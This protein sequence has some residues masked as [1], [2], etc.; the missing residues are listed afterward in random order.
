M[1]KS[2]LL[3]WLQEAYRQWEVFL[4]QFDP[5]RMDQPGVTGSWSMKDVVAHLTGWNRYLVARLQAAQRGE[6]EPQPP[7]P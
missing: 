7:P 1:K 3:Y 6:T 4:D 2:A 5:S